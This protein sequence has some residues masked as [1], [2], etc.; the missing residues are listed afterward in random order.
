MGL[1]PVGN[2]P[3]HEV[4]DHVA[5]L[6]REAVR[7]VLE[8][9]L[10]VPVEPKAGNE[11]ADLVPIYAP[12]AGYVLE[13]NI[14]P[15]RTIAPGQ[16]AFVIGDLSQVW[17]LASVRQDNL[18]ALRVGQEA[19]VTLPG[20]GDEHFVGKITNLGQ[21]LD[22]T[23]RAMQVRIVLNNPGQRLHP[24]MLANAEIPLG[25]TSSVLTVSSDAVQQ[26]NGQDI[27]FVRTAP[28]R[29]VVRPVR[30]G[31]TAD[32]KTPI[33]EG[34]KAGELVVVRGSFVLKSHLLRSTM[35]GN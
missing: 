17:M 9:D 14:T 1:N 26:I 24:E 29:F 3:R 5:C 23:T 35:E 22:P 6:A 28:D 11:D 30:V 20:L 27:V 34:L 7:D 8:D 33:L 25:Q 10:R 15:G 32:A 19:T 16:D 21:E 2:K 12:A 13:R 31:T 4:M 18:G